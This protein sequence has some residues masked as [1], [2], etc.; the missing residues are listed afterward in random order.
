MGILHEIIEYKR[1][2]VEERKKL[3]PLELLKKTVYYTSPCVSLKQYVLR[4]D[5][6]GIIAEFKKK[7][8]SKGMINAY[9][10]IEKI[11]IGYMQAGASALSILTDEHFFGG[12]NTDLMTAR[13]FNYCPVLRK[14]FIIDEYQIEEAKSIGADAILLIA[15]VLTKGEISRFIQKA[16]SLQMEVLL[17]F[18]KEEELEKYDAHADLVG[19]NN[20]NLQDFSVQ[21]NHAIH[22]AHQLPKETVKIAESGIQEPE[23]ILI[24]KE[25]SFDGY[26]IGTL[27]MQQVA[28]EQACSQFITKAQAL[29]QKKAEP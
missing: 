17:E 28:P 29:L 16:H 15:A 21:F 4:T 27:F 8:P 23:D 1:K 13:K 20:R 10:E 2:E 19:I 22:L 11:S 14:D 6:L 26:L 12:N 5:K 25:A 18:Y 9:A 7:S 3:Y 24:L